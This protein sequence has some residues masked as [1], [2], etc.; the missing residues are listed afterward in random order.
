MEAKKFKRSEGTCVISEEVIA[1]IACTAALEVD[2]VAAMAQRPDIRTI[3]AGANNSRYVK[4][5][6]S[7]SAMT[8]DVYLSIVQGYRIPDVSEQVQQTVKTEVQDMTGKPVT[9]V[10]VHIAGMKPEEEKK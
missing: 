7:E 9:R 8:L 1:T 3:I 2:G 10:N 6:D 4:V 5:S